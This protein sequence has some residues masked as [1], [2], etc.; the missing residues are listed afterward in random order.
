MK[1]PS[2]HNGKSTL[3]HNRHEDRSAH[4]GQSEHTV[5][6][7]LARIALPPLLSQMPILKYLNTLDAS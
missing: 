4:I 7:L 1:H 3:C 6:A 2:P 5:T